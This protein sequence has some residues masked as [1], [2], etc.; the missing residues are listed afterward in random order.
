VLVAGSSGLIGAAVL[1]GLEA[2]GHRPIRLVRPATP[3]GSSRPSVGWDPDAGDL[4]GRALETMAQPPWAVVN[5]GGGESIG[6][7][8]WTARRRRAIHSSRVGSTRVLSAALS[9]L[10]NRPV[11]FLSASAVGYYGDAGNEV[12]TE[13]SGP[14]T[15]F[16]AELVRDWEDA[17]RPAE[18]AGIRTVWLRTGLVL[19]GEGGLLTRFL[20]PFRLGLGGRLGSGAQ[21]MSW[22]SLADQ[23]G[24]VLHLLHSPVGGPVNVTAPN[25]VTNREFTEVLGRV[26][27][28][29]TVLRV[30]AFALRARFGRQM[31]EETALAS[32]RA[33]PRRLLDSGYQFEHPELEPALRAVLRRPSRV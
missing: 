10:D 1:G 11:A 26:L 33:L 23:V 29:P 5:V 28:R 18:D 3:S 32:Q 25:P 30:P 17:T 6:A 24:A 2:G 22:I 14:G 21:W 19:S 31:V 8:R 13:E 4:D 9:A 16:A 12:L 27:R 20:L 7:G 15:G